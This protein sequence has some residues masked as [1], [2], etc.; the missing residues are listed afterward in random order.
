MKRENNRLHTANLIG[1]VLIVSG[2][3]ALALLRRANG[4]DVDQPTPVTGS[5]HFV[6]VADHIA[7]AQRV[8]IAEMRLEALKNTHIGPCTCVERHRIDEV[9]GQ[10]QNV[11]ELLKRLRDD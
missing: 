9:V 2:M 5:G 10:D 4:Q 8:Y 3:A 7:L 11:G 6:T 1:L